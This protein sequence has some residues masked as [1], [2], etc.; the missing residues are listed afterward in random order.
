MGP[1]PN[2]STNPDVCVLQKEEDGDS[3]TPGAPRAPQAQGPA[4]PDTKKAFEALAAVGDLQEQ[5][6]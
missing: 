2:T 4:V 5:L 6:V 3:L 1:L